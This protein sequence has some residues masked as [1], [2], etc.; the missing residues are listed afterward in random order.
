MAAATSW[1]VDATHLHL[2]HR[3]GAYRLSRTA[4]IRINGLVTA[5][6]RSEPFSGNAEMPTALSLSTPFRPRAFRKALVQHSSSADSKMRSV[7]MVGCSAVLERI[8]LIQPKQHLFH[9]QNTFIRM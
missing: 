3:Q 1:R 7:L 5:H 6:G 4:T 8:I 9:G 2:L